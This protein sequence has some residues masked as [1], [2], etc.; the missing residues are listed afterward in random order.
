[1]PC[2]AHHFSNSSAS[3]TARSDFPSM[4]LMLCKVKYFKSDWHHKQ[5]FPFLQNI[6]LFHPST[7]GR[8]FFPHALTHST[9]AHLLDARQITWVDRCS[10]P[11]RNLNF[12]LGFGGKFFWL[13]KVSRRLFYSIFTP[14]LLVLPVVGSAPRT[15][16]HAG[17]KGTRG[18]KG[19][20][21]EHKT[22]SSCIGPWPV[23]DL[24]KSHVH[25][26]LCFPTY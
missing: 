22:P 11:I 15:Q 18:K 24:N 17:G 19:K 3:A 10:F 1:M 21:L 8:D 14:V 20:L 23:P 2:S 7:K 5:T 13:G 9:R 4:S 12:L 25:T 6:D 26:C 16:Q